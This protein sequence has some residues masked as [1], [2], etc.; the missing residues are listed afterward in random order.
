M[1]LDRAAKESGVKPLAW[2]AR[3][4]NFGPPDMNR[5][6]AQVIS[7]RSAHGLGTDFAQRSKT[8]GAAAIGIRNAVTVIAFVS[9]S[10]PTLLM[11]EFGGRLIF[12]HYAALAIVIPVLFL[13]GQ[14]SAQTVKPVLPVLAAIFLSTAIHSTT[15]DLAVAGFHSLHLVAIML[16]AACPGIVALRFAK[17]VII[18]YAVA[19]LLAQSLV[20]VGL[21]NVVDWLLIVKDEVGTPRVAAFATEPSYA[22]MILLILARF[23]IVLDI[24]WFTPVRLGLILG[25]LVATLSLFALISALLILAMYLHRR[26]DIR[27]MLIVLFGGALLLV[28]ISYTDFFAA[29]LSALD[30]S[31][32]ATGLG[33]GTVRLQPYLYMISILPSNPW[34][35]VYGAGA[36][37]LEQTFFYALGNFGSSAGRLT[38]HMAGP[39]YDYGLMAVLPILLWWNQPKNL[40]ER[41]LYLL[42]TVA[43]LLNTGIGSYLF[44]LFGTFAL[45][46]QRLRLA[47]K[48]NQTRRASEP[49]R[50]QGKPHAP[51]VS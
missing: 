30:L 10:F 3:S 34:P 32:G 25:S 47:S 49:I 4:A 37:N 35:I 6:T 7:Q 5:E 36:G 16:L 13:M 46:E 41:S 23:V 15:A 11:F 33:T 1:P 14:A 50:D 18:I 9:L 12:P 31:R 20:V 27:A 44:I 42:L 19:I 38:M 21:S 8:I 2:P 28:A 17:T 39:I 29:R 22:A 51:A 43:V 45:L 48:N 26:G 40:V 24:R